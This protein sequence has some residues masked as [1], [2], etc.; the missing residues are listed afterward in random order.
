[1]MN[2]FEGFEAR[3]IEVLTR[4]NQQE[5]YNKGVKGYTPLNKDEVEDFIKMGGIEEAKEYGLYYTA[6][7]WSTFVI[8]IK[9]ILKERG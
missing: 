2:I 1:M 7:D 3:H 5:M 4:E 8:V 6:D 9:K